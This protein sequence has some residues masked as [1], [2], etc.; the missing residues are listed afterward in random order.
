MTNVAQIWEPN[1]ELCDNCVW[2]C[3]SMK[4]L[5]SWSGFQTLWRIPSPEEALLSTKNRTPLLSTRTHPHPTSNSGLPARFP[6][7]KAAVRA[8]AA[9][10][11]PPA[12]LKSSPPVAGGA[13]VLVASVLAPRHSIPAR[14][15]SWS[16][17][18]PRWS[19]PLSRLFPPLRARRIR[20]ISPSPVPS[21]RYLS[22]FPPS[23]RRKRRSN[24]RSRSLPW[25]RA[26]FNRRRLLGN[27]CIARSPRHP[28]GGQAPWALKP[29][30]TPVASATSR[31]DS[32][33][34]TGL[35]PAR[36]SFRP[37]TPIPTRKFSRWGTT[38]ATSQPLL[39]PLP[40]PLPL[41][42]LPLC[43]SSFRTRITASRWITFIW[44]RCREE[45]GDTNLSHLVTLLCYML[46]LFF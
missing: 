32:S 11:T 33:P 27:V 18:R 9:R 2:H 41:L 39:G 30:A 1:F 25:R 38:E 7:S 24:C 20:R 29:F 36:H 44:G 13:D 22:S 34:N 16:H 37:C 46:L 40:L 23:R 45:L 14:Q 15:F 4:T 12:A 35:Q 21:S 5:F 3:Y 43:R 10:R 8:R 17:R 19:R 28:S 31:A 26:R 6:S 42:W